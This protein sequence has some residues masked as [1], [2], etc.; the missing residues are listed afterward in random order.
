[1]RVHKCI[2]CGHEFKD[3]RPFTKCP[4]CESI[5][6]TFSKEEENESRSKG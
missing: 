1:M 5:G 4:Q 6:C 2:I 3:V